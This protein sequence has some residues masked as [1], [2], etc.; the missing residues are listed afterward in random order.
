MTEDPEPRSEAVHLRFMKWI[1]HAAAP[2]A[3]I[4]SEAKDL[5]AGRHA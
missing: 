2:R 4:L 1:T 5:Y 3:I